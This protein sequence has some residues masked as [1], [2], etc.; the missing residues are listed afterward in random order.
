MPPKPVLLA[1]YDM[2][3]VLSTEVPEDWEVGWGP[4]DDPISDADTLEEL[5]DEAALA[6]VAQS[7]VPRLPA[8]WP[9][10][11]PPFRIG[12]TQEEEEEASDAE[13]GLPPAWPPTLHHP[14]VGP[15]VFANRRANRSRSPTPNFA[16]RLRAASSLF[17]PPH[18]DDPAWVPVVPPRFLPALMVGVPQT[19]Y[20]QTPPP[21]P[22]AEVGLA[23]TTEPEEEPPSSSKGKPKASSVVTGKP[24]SSGV[25][26]KPSRG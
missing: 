25:K 12:V 10:R 2:Q 20:T 6:E 23:T 11:L 1:T 13:V 18:H 24:K 14:K 26:K 21:E 22:Y 4:S 19:K 16:S 9:P 5:P 15:P 3:G 7:A 8:W 17:P